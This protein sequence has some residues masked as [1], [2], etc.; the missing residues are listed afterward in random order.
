MDTDPK[1]TLAFQEFGNHAAQGSP[2]GMPHQFGPWGRGPKSKP[3][4]HLLSH[5]GTHRNAAKI[6]Q[7]KRFFFHLMDPERFN[8]H[9]PFQHLQHKSLK[10]LLDSPTQAPHRS[11][12]RIWRAPLLSSMLQ[13][14]E[15]CSQRMVFPIVWCDISKRRLLQGYRK[16][17]SNNFPQLP[18]PYRRSPSWGVSMTPCQATLPY[19]GQQIL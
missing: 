14:A 11:S 19:W 2:L 10:A 15:T 18:S 1:G 12:K 6:W 9:V 5:T 13:L 7:I 17:L 4:H 8:C 3:K 16:L